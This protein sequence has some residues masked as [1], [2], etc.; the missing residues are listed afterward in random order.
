MLKVMSFVTGLFLIV[1]AAVAQGVP[2]NTQS[3]W[4]FMGR[5]ADITATVTSAATNLFPSNAGGGNVAA[6]CNTGSVDVR[7][8]GSTITVTTTNGSILKAGYCNNYLLQGTGTPPTFNT[9]IAT[10]TGSSTAVITVEVGFGNP[11]SWK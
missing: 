7:F 11:I 3:P 9:Y 10:I 2:P 8:G 1:S 4:L 6:V 5:V